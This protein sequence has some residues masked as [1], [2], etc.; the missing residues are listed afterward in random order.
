MFCDALRSDLDDIQGGT[1]PEG[2]H[3]GAMAGTVDIVQRCYTGIE[4]R[5]E[6]LHIDPSLPETL[7][8]LRTHVRYRK[9]ILDIDIDHETVTIS[10]RPFTA[11]P[12]TIAYR[13]HVRQMSP[14]QSHC[15]HLVEPPE[16]RESCSE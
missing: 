7:T 16:L 2:I 5:E 10:S 13:G 4:T 14:G 15:F 8:R 9:Q 3:L 11:L 12:I 6:A 1:T